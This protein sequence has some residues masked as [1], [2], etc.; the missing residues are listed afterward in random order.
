MYQQFW[1]KWSLEYLSSLQVREKWFSDSKTLP[2]G[3]VVILK[4]ENLAPLNWLLG[5]ITEVFPGKD[6]IVRVATVRTARGE[7]KRPICK[8]AP[9]PTQ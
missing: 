4:Q 6:G 3:T 5:V 1:K 8:L 9:L 2:P 7:Y